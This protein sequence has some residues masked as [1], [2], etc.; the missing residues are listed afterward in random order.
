VRRTVIATGVALLSATCALLPAAAP[1]SAD[2]DAPRASEARVHEPWVPL[3]SSP[4]DLAAGDYC[5]FPVHGDPIVDEVRV[6]TVVRYPDG[7]PKRQLA[8]GALM[9]RI[10]NTESGASTVADAGGSAVFDLFPDGSQTWHVIGPVLARFKDGVA[11]I[12]R[13]VWTIDGVYD[14]HFSPTGFKTVTIFFG[15]VH[16]VC[17]D[18][19]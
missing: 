14:V 4:F 12:P 7:S 6:K 10:T 16:D 5:A 11:N 9:F 18:L 2:V 13:G 15:G 8:T 3:P 1:A 19:D 17:A